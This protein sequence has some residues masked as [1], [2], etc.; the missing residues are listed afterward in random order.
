VRVRRCDGVPRLRRHRLLQ[1]RRQRGDRRELLEKLA[2]R[3]F[4]A[5]RLLEAAQGFDQ[6]ERVRAQ[7][8]ERHF[9]VQIARL[10]PQDTA[11]D[12]LQRRGDPGMA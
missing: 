3:Q 1:E 7:F 2:D 8:E 9:D 10:D 12:P 6:G 4:D 5:E 11:D